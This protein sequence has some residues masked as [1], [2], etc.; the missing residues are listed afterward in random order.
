MPELRAWGPRSPGALAKHVW[1]LFST[2]IN[3]CVQ[4]AGL[5]TLEDPTDAA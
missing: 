1:S 3:G 4:C 5:G 2:S